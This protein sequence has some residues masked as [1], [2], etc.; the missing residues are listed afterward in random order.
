LEAY[1]NGVQC[2]W[3]SDGTGAGEVH[4][5][6][7]AYLKSGQAI[8]LPVGSGITQFGINANDFS[9]LGTNSQYGASRIYVKTVAAPVG[10]IPAKGNAVEFLAVD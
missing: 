7:I 6:E 2:G 10:G 1:G 9:P 5:I 4:F 3:T 8:I